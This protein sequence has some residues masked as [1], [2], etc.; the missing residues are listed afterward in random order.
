MRMKKVNLILLIA[1]IIIGLIISLSI[2]IFVFYSIFL[3]IGAAILI[4]IILDDIISKKDNRKFTLK[5]LVFGI[6]TPGISYAS[7][8]T[9]KFTIKRNRD[10][11]INSIYAYKNA[12]NKFPKDLKTLNILLGRYNYVVDSISDSFEIHGRGYYG[13]PETFRSKDSTW[14]IF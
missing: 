3:I 2:Y 14:T 12:H 4:G 9:Q 13:F 7:T 1:S 10:Q 11:I 6:L 5:V 8:E